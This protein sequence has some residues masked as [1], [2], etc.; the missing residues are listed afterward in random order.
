MAA[1][2][3]SGIAGLLFACRPYVLPELKELVLSSVDEKPAFID[4]T[5]SVEG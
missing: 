5:V 1:H 2:F 4:K 3:V